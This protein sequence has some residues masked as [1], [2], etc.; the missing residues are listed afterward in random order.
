MYANTSYYT[1]LYTGNV[2]E[3]GYM[4]FRAQLYTL[5]RAANRQLFLANSSE[6]AD[7]GCAV[8]GFTGHASKEP[9]LDA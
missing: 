2:L 3:G 8:N 1:I 7:A 4:N 5:A 9:H 6:M